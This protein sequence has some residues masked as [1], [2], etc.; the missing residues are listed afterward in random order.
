MFLFRSAAGTPI[1]YH[2]P[3]HSAAGTPIHDGRY[4]P[5]NRSS[6]GTP[7]H[8]V[9]YYT[10]SNR[11]SL[12]GTPMNETA[13]FVVPPAGPGGAANFNPASL[14]AADGTGHAQTGSQSDLSTGH[15][16]ERSSKKGKSKQKKKEKE[17]K[18]PKNKKTQ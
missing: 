14:I 7:L 2:S 6:T 12:A 17:K 16:A 4:T 3:V 10:P 11:S 18:K 13:T 1:G 5:M 9:G 15:A 8:E